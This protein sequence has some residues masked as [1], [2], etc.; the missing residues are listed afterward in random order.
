MFANDA[1]E[2]VALVFIGTGEGH[3]SDDVVTRLSVCGSAG[4]NVNVTFGVSFRLR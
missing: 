1:L 2:V 4:V 3:N